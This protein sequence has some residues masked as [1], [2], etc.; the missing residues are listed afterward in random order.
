MNSKLELYIK[1]NRKAFDDNEV[2]AGLWNKIEAGL[3]TKTKKKTVSL[4]TY[5]SIAASIVI[6]LGLVYLYILKVKNTDINIADVNVAFAQKEERFSGLITEK[7]DSLAIFAASNPDLYKRFT[8]DL[9][10]L[11]DDYERL[12][13]E[14]AT[15]P[16][17]F[18]VVNAMVKNRELQLQ[19]LKQQLR[20]INQVDDYKKVNQI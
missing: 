4:F 13:K 5:I 15:T 17:Q 20:I 18:Y 11:D 8:E 10:R 19:I 3:V 2:P 14:L 7:R 1:E 16:N 9:R 12:K 6:V